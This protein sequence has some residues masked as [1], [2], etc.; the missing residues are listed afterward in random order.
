MAR[1]FYADSR[2]AIVSAFRGKCPSVEFTI[3]GS[4]VSQCSPPVSD[5][6]ARTRARTC[7]SP[8]FPLKTG[9]ISSVTPHATQ[10]AT[11]NL[12]LR[13]RSPQ[14]VRS[15]GGRVEQFNAVPRVL[16]VE[17]RRIPFGA[18]APLG[19]AQDRGCALVRGQA[20]DLAR[21]ADDDRIPGIVPSRLAHVFRLRGAIGE[22][23]PASVRSRSVRRARR[24]SWPVRELAVNEAHCASAEAA[25]DIGARD[26][27]IS[28]LVESLEDVRAALPRVRA[29]ET[30]RRIAE[31]RDAAIK[32][33]IEIV[34]IDNVVAVYVEAIEDGRT[35][36]PPRSREAQ[37]CVHAG[38]DDPDG[39]PRLH[40]LAS[41]RGRQRA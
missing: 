17:P 39:H 41:E 7:G 25:L 37:R 40:V 9:S 27:A 14:R 21:P 33:A 20:F 10:S 24:Q 5:A 28:V 2:D 16:G 12:A 35:S 38:V 15:H 8:L 29:E 31:Q 30:G 23:D 18:D 3:V 22:V 36:A 4:A 19:E 34:P 26:E 11:N 6:S 32:A 13:S 1:A